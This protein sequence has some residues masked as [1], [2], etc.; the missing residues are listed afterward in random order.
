MA[1]SARTRPALPVFVLGLSLG[2]AGSAAPVHAQGAEAADG[3][4][5]VPGASKIVYHV[6][7][8]LHKVD[9]VST[10]VTGKARVTPSGQVQ[11]VVRVAADSFESGNVNRDAHV[12]EVVEAGSYNTIELKALC[13]GLSP[14]ASFPATVEKRCTGKLSFHGVD[15]K[16]EIP[17]K[18]A[19]ESAARLIAT[20]SFTLSLDAF[21]IERPSLM[22]VKVNDE[23]RVD[24]SVVFGR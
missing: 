22:F 14:P 1:T 23:L 11:V 9:G 10:Q 19:Y 6:V 7:H 20:S 15:L 17:V 13:D 18:L 5:V 4:S 2:L 21:K 12:K 24:A 3:Y 8:K 16:T